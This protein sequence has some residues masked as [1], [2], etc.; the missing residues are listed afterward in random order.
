[1]P[2]SC[3]QTAKKNNLLSLIKTTPEKEQKEIIDVNYRY[4]CLECEEN[5]SENNKNLP[6]KDRIKVPLD[7]DIG[8]HMTT[9]GHTRFE[10]IIIDTN[11]RMKDITV[12]P[13]YSKLVMKQWKKMLK[14]RD[15]EYS[16]SLHCPKCKRVITD[17]VD[18]FKHIKDMHLK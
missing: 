12:N 6:L 2:H 11:V 5:L 13:E 17:A 16:H 18:M 9:T 15:I 3:G 8:E 7:I 4:F 14:N 10:P 1:M